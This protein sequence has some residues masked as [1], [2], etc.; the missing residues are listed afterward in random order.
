MDLDHPFVQEVRANPHDDAPRLVFADWLEE[1]GD[2]QAELIRVQVELARLPPLDLRAGELQRVETQLLD[3]CAEQWLAPLRAL[4]A[5]GV[6]RRCFQR[7]LIER[8]RMT[9]A[10]FLQHGEELCR[11]APALFALELREVAG[12]MPQLVRRELPQQVTLLDLGSCKLEQ[13]ELELLAGAPWRQ[14]IAELSLAFNQINDPAAARLA[15]S[16]WPKL[17]RL[18]LS[19]NRLGPAGVAALTARLLAPRLTQLSL[20]VNKI[21][22]AGLEQLAQSPWAKTLAELDLGTTD[23][24]AAGVVRL[25]MSPLLQSLRWLSLRGNKLGSISDR[26]LAALAA[27]P[28]LA[29]LD[30]RATTRTETHLSGYGA[31]PADPPAVLRER[32]GDGLL[33]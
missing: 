32:L 16:D 9:G 4:G 19:V 3:E 11:Q 27:A 7:G 24:T 10:D 8:V 6:S 17:S 1:A 28:H 33:W 15:Q 30:L 5:S 22:D 29:H 20:A 21:G 14:Q 13:R 25:T 2:R 26:T 18:N 12:V 31:V 23:I